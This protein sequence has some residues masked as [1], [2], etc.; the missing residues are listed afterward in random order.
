MQSLRIRN[1]R[2]ILLIVIFVYGQHPIIEPINYPFAWPYYNYDSQH[3]TNAYPP[4][5]QYPMVYIQQQPYMSGNP[6]GTNSPNSL[7]GIQSILPIPPY[8]S[9]NPNIDVIKPTLYNDKDVWS[10]SYISKPD[11]H[12]K[13][14]PNTANIEEYFVRSAGNDNN[15]DYNYA[16]VDWSQCNAILRPVTEFNGCAYCQFGASSPVMCAR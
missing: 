1:H 3:S 10:E 9:T 8:S 6:F 11:I 2:Q 13:L 16:E 12:G 7:N 14:L 5:Q 15:K 4:P